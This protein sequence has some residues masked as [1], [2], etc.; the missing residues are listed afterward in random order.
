MSLTRKQKT[1]TILL[2]KK[3]KKGSIYQ[4]FKK[5]FDLSIAQR[6]LR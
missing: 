4:V 1:L 2:L 5:F 3:I 6:Q